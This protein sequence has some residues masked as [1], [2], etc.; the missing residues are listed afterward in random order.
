MIVKLD[1]TK[2][3][4]F[5]LNDRPQAQNFESEEPWAT[6][7]KGYS[8]DTY[9]DFTEEEYYIVLA[10]SGGKSFRIAD[11]SAFI[12]PF[13]Y[14]PGPCVYPINIF[15][16]VDDKIPEDWM[17]HSHERKPLQARELNI[18]TYSDLLEFEKTLNGKRV[19]TFPRKFGRYGLPDIA[20]GKIEAQKKLIPYICEHI[21]QQF[22]LNLRKRN[23][24]QDIIDLVLNLEDSFLKEMYLKILQKSDTPIG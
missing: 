20:E 1:P 10:I 6:I 2:R 3:P 11:G 12:K 13:G 23:L 4:P 18:F 16:V 15:K 5:N 8:W 22:E 7:Y 9:Y 17:I 21:I 19:Y 24:S 14:N